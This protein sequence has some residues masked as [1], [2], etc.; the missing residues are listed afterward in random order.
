[1]A[2][3]N[4]EGYSFPDGLGSTDALPPLQIAGLK[5]MQRTLRSMPGKLGTRILMGGLRAG[6]RE[7]RNEARQRA[8]VL[9]VPT[10]SRKPG[11]V[12]DSIVVKT[13]KQDRYGVYV[14][15]RKLKGKAIAQ[16]K[17]DSGRAGSQ[18]PDDPYYW[19]QLEFGNRKMR[20]RPFLRPAF[21]AKHGTAIRKFNLYVLRRLER[22][23]RK[24]A[25]EAGWR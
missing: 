1:M 16:F 15:I 12:R 21:D 13:S 19:W 24:I 4:I 10:R 5:E 2:D 25:I 18:N 23:A 7:I 11:T 22:E 17:R 20:A 14:G 8:P 6:A 9:R 3:M